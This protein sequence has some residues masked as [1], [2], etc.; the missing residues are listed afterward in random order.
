MP[1]RPALSPAARST[2]KASPFEVEPSNRAVWS[3]EAVTAAVGAEGGRGD[4]AAG[5]RA[6]ATPVAPSQMRAVLSSEAVT[7][8]VPSGLKT[9]EATRP[10]CPS[11]ATRV[12]PVA[13]SQM[14]AVCLR[15]R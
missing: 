10:P 3:P 14:R 8:C 4:K 7:T 15:R 13:A 12:A 5:P 9:A 11:S 2:V 1:V 6:R